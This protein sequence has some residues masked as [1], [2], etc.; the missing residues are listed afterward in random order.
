MEH[1]SV[2]TECPSISPSIWD[3]FF[4]FIQLLIHQGHFEVGNIIHPFC[5]CL[6]AETLKSVGPFYLLSGEVKDHTKGNEKNLLWS[7]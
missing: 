1:P 5:M 6:L 4:I 3:L 2:W 7:H